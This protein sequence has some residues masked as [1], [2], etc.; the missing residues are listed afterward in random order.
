MAAHGVTR[1]ELVSAISAVVLLVLMLVVA[2]YGVDG[3]PG[4]AGSPAR[5]VTTETGWEG[6]TGV[7]WL[8]LLTVLVALASVGVHAVRPPRQAVAGLRLVLLILG[9]ATAALLVLRVLIDL[10]DSD[11]VVDQKLG[12]LLGMAAGLGIVYGAGQAIREQRARLA[13]G[14][15]SGDAGR[16]EPG[17]ATPGR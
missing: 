12:A 3:I 14:T 4:R 1:G 9:G 16:T 15:L 8:V 13:A 6:L 17:T 11:R 2:W 7:R 5:V 10:P